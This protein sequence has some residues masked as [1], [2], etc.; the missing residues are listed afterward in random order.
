[1]SKKPLIHQLAN[2]TEIPVEL[3]NHKKPVYDPITQQS[4]Y[5]MDGHSTSCAKGTDGTEP[6]NE[7]D[8]VMDDN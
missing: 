1:M 7:A 3:I 6:K 4:K 5:F 8:Q 2:R